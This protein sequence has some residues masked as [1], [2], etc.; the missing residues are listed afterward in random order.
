[1]AQ[2]A[3][4]VC[5]ILGLLVVVSP[6][7]FAVDPQNRKQIAKGEPPMSEEEYATALRKSRNSGIVIAVVGA[8]MFIL[9][10]VSA[11]WM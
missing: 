8:A 4:L 11:Q 1:M 6:A 2:I 10:T 9:V 3:G 5:F 7:K